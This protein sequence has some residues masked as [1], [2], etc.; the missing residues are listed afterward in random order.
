MR[1]LL[2]LLFFVDIQVSSGALILQDKASCFPAEVL[3]GPCG[4]SD[5]A[6]ACGAE[7]MRTGPFDVIDACAA[8]GNKTSH[9]A[10]L[11]ETNS[12]RK[13]DGSAILA[14]DK[15]KPRMALLARRMK[16]AGADKVRHA[17]RSAVVSR[18]GSPRYVRH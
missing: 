4:D 6:S 2:V 9:L 14:F 17:F 12:E 5:R 8:P 7:W 3:L 16:Q 18:R 11:L 13:A 1:A 10:M 15:S